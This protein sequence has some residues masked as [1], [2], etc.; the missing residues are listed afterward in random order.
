MARL[1]FLVVISS[2]HVKDILFFRTDLNEKQSLGVDC[3]NADFS[4]LQ[5]ISPLTSGNQNIRPSVTAS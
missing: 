1:P 5:I 3:Y 4:S 2:L